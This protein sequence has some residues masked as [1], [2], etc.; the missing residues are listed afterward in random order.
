M[1]HNRILSLLA[2]GLISYRVERGRRCTV[3]SRKEQPQKLK[4]GSRGRGEVNI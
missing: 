2:K 4:N 3:A 1:G